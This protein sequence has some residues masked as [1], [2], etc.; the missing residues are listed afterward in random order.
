M[1]SHLNTVP[2][3]A[4]SNPRYKFPATWRLG[5]GLPRAARIEFCDESILVYT[6][7]FRLRSESEY[8]LARRAD[9]SDVRQCELIGPRVE[10]SRF[11]LAGFVWAQMPAMIDLSISAPFCD[12]DRPDDDSPIKV[13]HIRFSAGGLNASEFQ[14]MYSWLTTRL[15]IER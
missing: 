5:L 6:S 4:S 2:R 3:H 7:R 11:T 15:K 1:E 10:S 14:E 8:S 9:Y 12:S 13:G